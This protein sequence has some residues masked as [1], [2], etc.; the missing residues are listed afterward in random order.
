MSAKYSKSI[1]II[2]IALAVLLGIKYKDINSDNNSKN[3]IKIGVTLPLTGDVAS[4]GIA[5]QTAM[6]MALEKW[7]NKNTKYDYQ[8][9]FEDNQLMPNKVALNA[10][11]LVNV[12][13][14]DAITSIWGFVDAVKGIVKDKEIINF[15]C[16]WGTSAAKG[17]Y[18]F[19]HSTPPTAQVATLIEKFNKEGIKK[20]GI[21]HQQSKSD[22]ELI[23]VYVPALEKAGF[24]I[25]YKIKT[26]MD[27]RD[28]RTQIAKLKDKK[29][30]I[31]LILAAS[32]SLEIIRK[33]MLE[34]NYDV[35]LT[36]VDY[37]LLADKKE[38]FEGFWFVADAAGNNEFAKEF[39][40]KSEMSLG[41][42]VANTY[43]M[44]DM[45][46]YAYENTEANKDK[47]ANK[48]VVNTLHN[49]KDWKG[50]IGKLSIDD[51]GQVYSK[52]NLM[53]IKEGKIININ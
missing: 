20:V 52:A 51:N 14:V 7:K 30:D 36:T 31:L 32:P 6:N 33:Q 11:R 23:D 49:I 42:C 43:D 15:A 39:A 16:S 10:N 8:L 26:A 4:V 12:E 2:L 5:S 44:V 53:L 25:V 19:N 38:L 24:E 48:D 28:Y 34:S 1:I 37:F 3:V 41:G 46:I 45:L 13:N 9:I 21:W 40:T 17:Y 29:V 18:N 22:Y 35:P 50:A 27:D 47:P